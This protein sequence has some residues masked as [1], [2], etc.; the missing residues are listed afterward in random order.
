MPR[1]GSDRAQAGVEIGRR[2]D[3]RPGID[4]HGKEPPAPRAGTDDPGPRALHRPDTVIAGDSA[5]QGCEISDPEGLKVAPVLRTHGALPGVPHEGLA[6][7]DGGLLPDRRAVRNSDRVS[8][9]S[10][11][12]AHDSESLALIAAGAPEPLSP[13]P[14][15]ISFLAS[16][17]EPQPLRSTHETTARESNAV[18]IRSRILSFILNPLSVDGWL[19]LL[20]RRM[21]PLPGQIVSSGAGRFRVAAVW[22]PA[23]R[24]R[25]SS[26]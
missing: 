15:G 3:G 26:R 23:W 11:D 16:V 20:E 6:Q 17:A 14:G 24:P 1:N 13:S 5:P 25:G 19:G 9:I 12:P 18:V 7:A 4:D 8:L 22:V 2:A 10:E 21:P